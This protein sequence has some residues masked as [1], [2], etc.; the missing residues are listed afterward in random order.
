REVQGSLL[1]IPDAADDEDRIIVELRYA[2]ENLSIKTLEEYFHDAVDYRDEALDLFARGHLGLEDRAKAE[3]LFHRIRLA[4]ERLISQMPKPPE[5]IV[6][7]LDR[8]QRKYLANFSIFQ[9]LPDSWSVDQVFPAAPLSRYGEV[10]TV[11]AS[12]VDITCD[13]DGCIKTFAHPDENLKYLTLH[14]PNGDPYFLGF[15]MTGAYQDSLANEHNLFS[16][17]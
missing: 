16:R 6:D 8:A 12:I 10:P 13:S 5:E 15:F 1:P 11:N 17:C 3:G 2:L 9:S 4:A 7:Y 14:P